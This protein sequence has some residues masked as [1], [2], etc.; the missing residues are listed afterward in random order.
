MENN[1]SVKMYVCAMFFFFFLALFVVAVALVHSLTHC[2]F[3]YLFSCHIIHSRHTPS[4]WVTHKPLQTPSQLPS[5]TVAAMP[6]CTISVKHQA[7]PTDSTT[8]HCWC[9]ILCDITGGRGM[10]DQVRWMLAATKVT[11]SQ[12]LVSD[13]ETFLR[14]CDSPLLPFNQ[15]PVLQIDGTVRI[16]RHIYCLC[17]C[18]MWSVMH[19][20]LTNMVYFTC[21]YWINAI[22]WP[23][24]RY[25]RRA[26]PWCGI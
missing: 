17:I 6:P 16:I 22:D 25:W 12:T 2:M 7:S 19:T 4:S 20:L 11:F 14:L 3:R 18:H 23:I 9:H 8:L 21:I 5:R 10:A 15:I 13:R 1:C 26:K 24:Y